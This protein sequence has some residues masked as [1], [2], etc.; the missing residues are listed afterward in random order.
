MGL[1]TC[2]EALCLAHND[3]S[4]S[5]PEDF[6][7][8]A[9][10]VSVDLSF[11]KL[12]GKVRQILHP[13]SKSTTPP[14]EWNFS[15]LFLRV[16]FTLDAQ[17]PSSVGARLTNLTDLDISKN[18]ISGELPSNIGAAS[19]VHSLELGYY[20][21]YSA[22]PYTTTTKVAPGSSYTPAVLRK[23]PARTPFYSAS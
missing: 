8:S 6:L 22:T 19:K 7:S 14:R 1:L 12:E 13:E 18:S 21:A 4:E 17:I 2:L 3:L 10:L 15:S 11:N 20:V 9:A 23:R 5:I 16:H